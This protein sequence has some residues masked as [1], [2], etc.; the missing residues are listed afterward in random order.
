MQEGMK[1]LVLFRSIS[2]DYSDIRKIKYLV[3]MYI[4]GMIYGDDVL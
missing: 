1:N 3:K 2:F 4:N